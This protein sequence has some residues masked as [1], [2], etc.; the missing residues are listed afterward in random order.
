MRNHQIYKI[1]Y[2]NGKIY[3]GKDLTGTLVYFG[4]PNE[5]LIALDF[6]G[7]DTGS[8]SITKEILWEDANDVDN[9]VHKKEME[10]IR[11]LRSNNPEIGYNRT[12][13][14]KG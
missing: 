5:E 8:F 4:S 3:V 12:P 2:P 6:A 14:F 13:K 1:T 10:F 7:V 11:L 9:L